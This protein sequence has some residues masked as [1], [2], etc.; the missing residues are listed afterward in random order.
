MDGK[1]WKCPYI[2]DL[3]IFMTTTPS[4]HRKPASARISNDSCND[5]G[6]EKSKGL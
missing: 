1:L 5:V 3:F 2:Q 6:N 4:S